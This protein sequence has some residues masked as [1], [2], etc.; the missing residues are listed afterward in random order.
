MYFKAVSV[1]TFAYSHQSVMSGFSS[2]TK[3]L[4]IFGVG[5]GIFRM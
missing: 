2:L 3:L 4:T 5:D 1:R